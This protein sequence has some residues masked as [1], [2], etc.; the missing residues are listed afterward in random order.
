MEDR[1]EYRHSQHAPGVSVLHAHYTERN[2]LV[3]N[4]SYGLAVPGSWVGEL[5]YRGRSQVFGAGELFC[6]EPGEVHSTSRIL[7]PGDFKVFVI[8]EAPL[9]ERLAE[10]APE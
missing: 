8:D 3:A 6:T 10:I 4:S 7:K 1:L 5:S 9:A 2:W